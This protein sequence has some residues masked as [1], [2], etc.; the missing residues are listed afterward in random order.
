M[1]EIK[2]NSIKGVS[3][4]TAA[5]SIDNSSGTCTANITNNLSNRN[6]IINGAMQVAQRGTARAATSQ[7]HSF[8]TVDRFALQ[9]NH[10]GVTATETQGDVG[11]SDTP[12]TLGFRKYHRL[13]LASAGTANTNAYIEYRYKIEAQ[14][15]ANSG[16]DY[17]SSSSYLTFSFWFRC[18]T[19]Q[20][21]YTTFRS[22]DGGEYGYTFSFTASGN[23]TWTKVTH[24]I[25]GNSNLQFNSDN[26]VGLIFYMIPFYGTQYTDNSVSLNSWR[27]FSSSAYIP[28]IASTWLTAGASTIDLTGVQLEVGSHATDFE[29]RSYAVE[30][31][32]CDRYYQRIINNRSTEPFGVGNIDGSTQAQIYISLPVEMRTAPT[33]MEVQNNATDIAMRVRSNV[34]CTGFNFFGSGRTNAFLEIQVSTGHGF[35]DGQA[36][37]A[38]NNGANLF[39]AFSAEL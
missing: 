3:A 25:P 29:H 24:S 38:V 9:W 39:L 12:F 2:V 32:L 28:D 10:F 11:S 8:A 7:G 21:F 22:S 37:F 16:W 35:T 36:A 13:A 33:S 15:I 23:N 19:N 27:A 17:T 14:D 18:S 1:S 6:L 20:T 30:K 31:R 26:G 4:S 34:T 5:I